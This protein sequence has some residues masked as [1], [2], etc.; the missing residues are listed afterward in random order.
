MTFP[1]PKYPQLNEQSA[2]L[3]RKKQK[4]YH[5]EQMPSLRKLSSIPYEKADRGSARMAGTSG[6]GSCPASYWN[7]S[8]RY[9]GYEG[10]PGSVGRM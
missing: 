7:K 4:I 10:N 3:A 9:A 5:Y 1:P 2:S 8:D 6:D